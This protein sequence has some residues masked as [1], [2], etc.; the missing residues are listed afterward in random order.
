MRGSILE[1]LIRPPIDVADG[2]AFQRVT[3][4]SR[5]SRGDLYQ[6]SWP[7]SSTYRDRWL[8]TVF[9]L[10]KIRPADRRSPHRRRFGVFSELGPVQWT[11]GDRLSRKKKWLNSGKSP[12]RPPKRT[13]VSVEEIL[14]RTKRNDQPST[15]SPQL[16]SPSSR[17]RR[18]FEW[19]DQPFEPTR[20]GW[21]NAT[22]TNFTSQRNEHSKTLT[23]ADTINPTPPPSHET[24]ARV[25]CS[26]F[27][28]SLGLA[29]SH[30][31]LNCY[32]VDQFIY[33][34]MCQLYSLISALMGIN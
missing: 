23:D 29:F 9:A 32:Q 25:A 11:D 1:S 28:P 20:R 31:S 5:L 10:L 24:G 12:S 18:G 26:T 3:D 17:R 22:T 34:P 6:P 7:S 33:E 14:E 4:P 16:E 8:I 27:C 13:S 21:Q 30:V 15:R 19:L 2:T